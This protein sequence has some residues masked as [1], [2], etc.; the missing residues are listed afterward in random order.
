[1]KHRVIAILS[2]LVFSVLRAGNSADYSLI[3]RIHPEPVYVADGAFLIT[4]GNDE[5]KL[6]D[7]VD[8]S[9]DFYPIQI[10]AFR[11]KSN[12]EKMFNDVSGVI[13]D[14]V[15]LIEEDGYFK[16]RVTKLNLDKVRAYLEPPEEEAVQQEGLAEPRLVAGDTVNTASAD[17][18]QE[19]ARVAV[20]PHV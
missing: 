7:I 12:A 20:P 3:K 18:L 13:G 19:E 4:S 8:L 5:E 11:V 6:N 14:D 1:M 10:G 16:V 17:T 2:L 15:T 9:K